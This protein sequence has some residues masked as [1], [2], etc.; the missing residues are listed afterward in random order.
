[1]TT[2]AIN[3]ND[4]YRITTTSTAWILEKKINGDWEMFKNFMSLESLLKH[5]TDL[6]TRTSKDKDI[7][8]KY[9]EMNDLMIN[10]MTKNK[11]LLLEM[12]DD[13]LHPVIR[14][15]NTNLNLAEV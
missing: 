8:K 12:A 10:V 1:M 9:K 3:I 7:L 6:L 2:T 14:S 4:T 11:D 13:S 15:S 5:T